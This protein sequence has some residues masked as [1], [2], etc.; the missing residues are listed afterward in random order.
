MNIKD[1]IT[2]LI[3]NKDLSNSELNFIFNKII[4][5][6]IHE[7]LI[8]AILTLIT[9]NGFNYKN[10]LSAAKTLRKKLIKVKVPKNS[11]DTCGTGGDGKHTLNISTAAA[12]VL[13]GL[14]VYVVKH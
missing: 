10:I 2:K 14:E 12:I 4:N 6:E 3:L 7:N 8:T 1:L 13:A 11:I 5:A 9:R